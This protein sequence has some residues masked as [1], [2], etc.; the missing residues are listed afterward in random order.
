MSAGKRQITCMRVIIARD[1]TFLLHELFLVVG[2]PR[3]VMVCSSDWYSCKKE[4]HGIM[5]IIS[6]ARCKGQRL[7]GLRCISEEP[8]YLLGHRLFLLLSHSYK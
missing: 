8:V 1:L 7:L 2:Q 6:I 3:I 4:D 5:A